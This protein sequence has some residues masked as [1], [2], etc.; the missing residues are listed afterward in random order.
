MRANDRLRDEAIH[1]A[2]KRKNGLLRLARNDGR[3][4]FKELE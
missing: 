4:T 3:E 1:A 2:T